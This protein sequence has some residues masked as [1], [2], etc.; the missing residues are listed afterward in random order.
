M[1]E[2]EARA[3]EIR[4]AYQRCLDARRQ[5]M[6]VRGRTT[7]PR[8]REKA[9]ADLHEAVLS[10]FEALVPYISERPGEVKQLWE[11][12]PLYP[13]QP[14]TQKILV[15]ANDHAYL[16]NTEDGPSKTDLC[17]DCGTPLQPD[18]QPKRD[19]QGRQLFVWKQ[20]LK[21]LSSWTHQTVTEET[22]GGELSSATKTVE[23]PQ[24]LDPEIL[25]RAARYLDLAAEQ[26][27]LLATTDDAIATGEL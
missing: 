19:E 26:C 3:T 15:C 23:R 8:Y 12:A 9:H 5:W 7:D 10:W 20:G 11:G 21:N 4:E 13:V 27:S 22:S 6:S 14:V 16:R 25:M 1:A 24:R 18:E 17:P 2:S